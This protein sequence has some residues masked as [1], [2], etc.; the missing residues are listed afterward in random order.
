MEI[1]EDKGK[2]CVGGW[3]GVIAREKNPFPSP[4]RWSKCFNCL[5]N[6]WK[7]KW[8]TASPVF[9]TTTH[10]IL[11]NIPNKPFRHLSGIW[12][13]RKRAFICVSF[14]W[15]KRLRQVEPNKEIIN[16][17]CAGILLLWSVTTYK[18]L[19][20][21]TWRNCRICLIKKNGS[22]YMFGDPHWELTDRIA[23]V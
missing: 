21:S 8:K 4:S 18:I 15:K 9:F 14:C 10:I 23:Y 1:Q 22:K 11:Q 19:F 12:K 13:D 16:M 7:H 5:G 2:F 3:V 6:S 20:S 17:L